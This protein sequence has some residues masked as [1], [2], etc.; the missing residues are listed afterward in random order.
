[1]ARSPKKT[2]KKAPLAPQVTGAK[3][4][5]RPPLDVTR[6][7]LASQTA[8][9]AE[10]DSF[11]ESARQEI[12]FNQTHNVSLPD[13]Y[14]EFKKVA[15]VQQ[16]VLKDLNTRY[17]K[18]RK[19]VE[20]LVDAAGDGGQMPEDL[21][22]AHD[23][24]LCMEDVLTGAQQ[25]WK[26]MVTEHGIDL[27]AIVAGCIDTLTNAGFSLSYIFHLKELRACFA[28]DVQFTSYDTLAE[29]FDPVGSVCQRLNRAGLSAEELGAAIASLIEDQYK[30]L[31]KSLV[32]SDL[33]KRGVTL[34]AIITFV[35]QLL[36]SKVFQ[37]A[38]VVTYD[39][40]NII[41]LSYKII[42]Y[43]RVFIIFVVLVI[44]YRDD[45]GG[46]EF[47]TQLSTCL[48]VLDPARVNI[49]RLQLSIA[50]VD[51]AESVPLYYVLRKT[52]KG[53]LV[54]DNARAVVANR[55]EETA[56]RAVWQGL[57]DRIAQIPDGSPGQFTIEVWQAHANNLLD[58]VQQLNKLVSKNSRL[59]V[60]H[61]DGVM[62]HIEQ[63][64]SLAIEAWD[65][66]KIDAISHVMGVIHHAQPG[67]H[68]S[69]VEVVAQKVFGTRDT[70]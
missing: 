52:E 22:I 65:T 58:I 70:V 51:E 48:D 24:L 20:A 39:T 18:I 38:I 42:V 63:V 60:S 67:Q 62:K 53:Q 12:V 23:K 14:K 54:M 45:I 47:G 19:R 37:G 64:T 26:A 59:H 7:G 49:D 66:F 27:G 46:A 29:L 41:M 44:L 25:L 9:L 10:I 35:E 1:M 56:G 34:L 8:L 31:F 68:L 28:H 50:S 69:F 11:V 13:E 32:G 43:L 33:K 57:I 17:G 61:H 3:R 6:A 40:M 4:R 16:A 2:P 15:T 55:E 30:A 21:E 36:A 5:G